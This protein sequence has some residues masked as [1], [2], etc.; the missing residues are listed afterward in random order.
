MKCLGALTFVLTI[1]TMQ[2]KS[3]TV[4]SLA[5]YYKTCNNCQT[6]I[7]PDDILTFSGQTKVEIEISKIYQSN[8]LFILVNKIESIQS[9]HSNL[10]Q[11][12]VYE[13]FLSAFIQKIRFSSNEQN[14]MLVVLYSIGDKQ[15]KWGTGS[16]VKQWLPDSKCQDIQNPSKLISE[17]ENTNRLLSIYSKKLTKENS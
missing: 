11:K 3:W 17:K 5:D 13:E 9:K 15:Y 12:T 2:S 8:T 4:D 7:N 6:V 1:I 16:H 10:S 14:R